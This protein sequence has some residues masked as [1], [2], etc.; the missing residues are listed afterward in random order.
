MGSPV[1]SFQPTELVPAEEIERR[2]ASFQV[3]LGNA[4]FDGALIVQSADLYYL[5]GTTQDAHLVVPIDREPALYVRKT[6]ERARSESPL[7]NVE[8]LTS[9]RYLA[10]ALAECGLE[11][12]RIGLELDVLPARAYLGYLERLPAFEFG[13]CSAALSGPRSVK[14]SWELA[15]IREAA[16]MIVDLDARV[17]DVVREGVPEVELAGEIEVWLRRR[18][19]QGIARM[20]A[21]NGDIHFGTVA[22]GIT[23]ATPGSPDAPLVGLG[24]NPYVAKGPSLRAIG[25]GEPIVIDVL[26]ASAGYLADQTRCFSIGPVSARMRRAYECSV[27]IVEQVSAAARPGALASSLFSL[28][29]SSPTLRSLADE[30]GDAYA[31]RS[32]VSFVG[33]GFGLELDEPPFLARGHDVPLEP[34]MVF[35]LEPKFVFEDEGAVGLENSYVVTETG[36]ELL[37]LAPDEL[38]EL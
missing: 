15:R 8:P 24:R 32:R 37:T 16:D 25:R 38:I 7:A 22:A 31:G 12:G 3:A 29:T 9:L 1:S 35:A 10:R 20:R 6:L 13:D 27:A 36:T 4:G 18:G 26:G 5:T 14:S 19:H 23:A 33:H 28:Q 2:I 30:F 34:G 17:R 21:F 11:R